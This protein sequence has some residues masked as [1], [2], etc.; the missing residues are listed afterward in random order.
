MSPDHDAEGEGMDWGH[1]PPAF[2]SNSSLGSGPDSRLGSV[3]SLDFIKSLLKGAT[4]S[5]FSFS[6]F[7][8]VSL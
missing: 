1:T 3:G 6:A 4:L 7:H 2:H 5:K 8:Y